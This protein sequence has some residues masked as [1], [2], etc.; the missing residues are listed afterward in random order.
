MHLV[1]NSVDHP[2]QQ[3]LFNIPALRVFPKKEA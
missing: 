3:D 2:W 1:E